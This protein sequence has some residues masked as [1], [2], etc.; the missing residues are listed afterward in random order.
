MG[1][2]SITYLDAFVREMIEHGPDFVLREPEEMEKII[3]QIIESQGIE[4]TLEGKHA[5]PIIYLDRLLISS[6]SS[7]DFLTSS[8]ANSISPP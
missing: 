8:S 1:E 2:H 3:R 4:P 7:L 5:P 6:T